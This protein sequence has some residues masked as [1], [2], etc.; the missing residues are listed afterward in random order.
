MS[1][2]AQSKMD[3]SNGGLVVGPV[4]VNHTVVW[5]LLVVVRE[6]FLGPRYTAYYEGSEFKG[7]YKG[8]CKGCCNARDGFSTAAE[9]CMSRLVTA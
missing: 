6:L 4:R 9:L 1:S 5:D 7:C 3:W 8:S 2:K